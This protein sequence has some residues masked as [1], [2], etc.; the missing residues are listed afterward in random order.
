MRT[1]LRIVAGPILILALCAGF[2]AHA[3]NR[4]AAPKEGKK[5]AQKSGVTKESAA[6]SAEPTPGQ[7]EKPKSREGTR[8]TSTAKPDEPAGAQESPDEKEIRASAKTF[9]E[10]Y[11]QHDSKGLGALFA[12]KAEMVEEDG[13]LVKGREAIEAEF[14]QQFKN[15]P[16]CTIRIDVASV[17]VLT[18]HIALEEGVARCV[19]APDE[20]EDVSHYTC[21][22]VK[23]D[24][25]WVVASATNFAAAAEE[26]TAHERLQEL[27]WLIGDW[28][29]ES[30]GMTIHSTCDWDQ[31][32]NFLIYHFLIQL[33]GQVSMSGTKRIAWDGVRKQFR[34]WVFD[35]EGGFSEG[36]WYR[37]GNEWL[38]KLNGVTSEGDT[39]SAIHVYRQLDPDTIA[40]RSH[41][42]IIDGELTGDISE[43]VIKR[44]AADPTR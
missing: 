3:Q 15:Q 25:K 2:L 9:T 39:C 20:P 12:P 34:S 44:R 24:D 38:V 42:R 14:A 1:R 31:T 35:S 10:L 41:D 5:S 4:E 33:P 37:E 19:A 17:R 13:K 21:V 40:F 28:I 22:H 11:N 26:M 23:V 27:A 29:D 7:A 32:G 43:A 16:E 30:P 8:E 36:L 18:P 6:Q